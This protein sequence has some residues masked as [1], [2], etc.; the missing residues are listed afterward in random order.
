MSS[1]D[2]NFV[3]AA[4]KDIL[5]ASERKKFMKDWEDGVISTPLLKPGCHANLETHRGRYLDELTPG[6]RTRPR[7]AVQ[8][9]RSFGSHM[10]YST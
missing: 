2:P 7:N 8:T 1:F 3:R 4:I 10:L 5:P 9:G 6:R